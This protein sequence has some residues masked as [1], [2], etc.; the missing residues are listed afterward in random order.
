MVFIYQYLNIY[1]YLKLEQ[2]IFIMSR[3][4]RTS[5]SFF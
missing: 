1:Q 3:T 2:K 5:T 4:G